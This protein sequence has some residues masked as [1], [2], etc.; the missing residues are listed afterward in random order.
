MA[1]SPGFLI[2]SEGGRGLRETW[3][4]VGHRERKGR[5]ARTDSG[6]RDP[7]QYRPVVSLRPCPRGGP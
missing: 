3:E 6:G 2:I 4:V 1:G 5:P 7:E